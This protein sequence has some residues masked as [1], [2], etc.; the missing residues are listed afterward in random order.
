VDITGLQKDNEQATDTGIDGFMLTRSLSTFCSKKSKSPLEH[1]Q[2]VKPQKS[3]TSQSEHASLLLVLTSTNPEIN[4]ILQT[5]VAILQG[6][7][8]SPSL[9]SETSKA[10]SNGQQ[11]GPQS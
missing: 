11:L 10:S 7:T 1:A 2:S 5:L 4:K 9:Q 8:I 3:S 6:Q